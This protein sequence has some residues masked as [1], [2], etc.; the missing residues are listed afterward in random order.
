MYTVMSRRWQD[1]IAC[2]IFGAIAA[3]LLNKA[4]LPDYTLLPLDLIQTIAPWDD[5]QLGP[6]A[7]PL[8]SDPFYAFYPHRLF[9][10]ESVRSG[11]I[12]LWDP[13]IMTGT[14]TVAYSNFQ[15]FYPPNLLAA[16]ILPAHQALPW[17]AWFHLTATGSLMYL[18]LR[19]H[20][21]RWLACMLGGGLW[22]LSGYN[23]VWLENPLPASIRRSSS[24]HSQSH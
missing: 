6:L 10:T 22:L 4:L 12:P 18:F 8:I 7:N 17:L 20:K 21:L 3:V 19:R 24:R 14:P 2:L 23:L 13:A 9:F 5:L 1:I 16:L 15:P 11:Q